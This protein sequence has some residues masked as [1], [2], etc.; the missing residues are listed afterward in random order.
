MTPV[1]SPAP[2]DAAALLDAASICRDRSPSEQAVYLAALGR[3][4]LSL[5]ECA[6]LPIGARD[7]AIIALRRAMFG[8]RIALS[9]L[10]PHCAAPIDVET[11]ADALIALAEEA[12]PAAS[13]VEIDGAGFA[14]RAATSADLAAVAGIAD[15]AAARAALAL[16]CLMPGADAPLPDTLD[17]AAIDAIAAA[18]AGID[19]AGDPFVTLTCTPCGAQWDAPIDIASV[20]ADEIGG[21]ADALL[22]EVDVIAR[23]YH[24]HEDAILAMSQERRRAYIARLQA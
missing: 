23:A 15:E 12:A 21:A 16:R 17:A 13:V 3:P 4:D 1:P 8:G 14:V 5:A 18:L 24:W 20:L 7:T 10:C 22:D 9:A 11:S 6:Q 19:P 2:L